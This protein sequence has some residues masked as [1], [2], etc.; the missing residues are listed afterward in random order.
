VSYD[1]T[2]LR[3][4]KGCVHGISRSISHLSSPMMRGKTLSPWVHR[5]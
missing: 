3:T 2:G 4:I 1:Q 5:Q